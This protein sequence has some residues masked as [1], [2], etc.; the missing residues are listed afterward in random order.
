MAKR[1]RIAMTD[2][3]R[4]E[5]RKQEQ[6]LTERAVAQLRCSAGWQRWLEVRARVGLRRLSVGNQL[7]VCL[8]DP[9]AT[10]VAGFR[11]W[12]TL[13]YCVRRGSASHIRIWAPCPPSKKKLQAWRDAGAVPGER[14]KTF[15][16]LEAVFTHAQ[17]D[18]L[19]PPAQP[20]VL[21]PPSAE[22]EG[23]SLAWAQGPLEQLAGELGYRLVLNAL[24][25][26]HGGSCDPVAKILTINTAQSVNAQISVTCHEL[27]HALVR[28]DRQP[29]D[30]ALGYA[31][32]ELVA[33]SVAHLAVSFV[34][35]DS[36][37]AAVPYLAGWAEAAAPDTFERIAELVDR[38][39]RRLEA[40]LGAKDTPTPT[41]NSAE[42]T[43]HSQA[44]GQ[45]AAIASRRV[46]KQ[47]AAVLGAAP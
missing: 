15:F 25:P 9:A 30:P 13:G 8:Q 28:H 39:A 38:L 6:Q 26:G 22:L 21:E 42:Y 31:E 23:D 12:L 35:L 37:V 7:L 20:A 3:E 5:R 43:S 16:R 32:E 47:L 41:D 44:S 14:P 46:A 2:E 36:S 4:A 19:P 11:A 10:Y 18:P 34:G 40:A 24:E 27:A 29:D 45:P 33:E 1:E 17:V